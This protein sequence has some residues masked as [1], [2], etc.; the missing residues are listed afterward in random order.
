MRGYKGGIRPML[1][2]LSAALREQEQFI[3]ALTR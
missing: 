3:D 2:D 1:R